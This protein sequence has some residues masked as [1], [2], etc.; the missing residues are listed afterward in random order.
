MSPVHRRD[1]QPQNVYCEFTETNSSK[2]HFNTKYFFISLL[3]HTVKMHSHLWHHALINWR[4]MKTVWLSPDR[5]AFFAFSS[6]FYF[7]FSEAT[8]SL[9]MICET[10]KPVITIK[11]LSLCRVK[12]RHDSSGAS[13]HYVGLHNID[14]NA[15][16]IYIGLVNQHWTILK[17][18]RQNWLS[19]RCVL[20]QHQDGK[21]TEVTYKLISKHFVAE[22]K[23]IPRKQRRQIHKISSDP[24]WVQRK[25]IWP[26]GK[27]QHREFVD[28][29]HHR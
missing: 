12:G 10:F 1:K 27:K 24:T 28:C 22:K 3:L 2:S 26:T 21:M 7:T 16:K 9:N 4:Y 19:W 25:Q 23:F 14:F 29:F 8:G 17:A 15:N 13:I 11:R 5:W 18:P 6:N 20:T